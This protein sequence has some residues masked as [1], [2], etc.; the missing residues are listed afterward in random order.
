MRRAQVDYGF[1]ATGSPRSIINGEH[2]Q[3]RLCSPVYFDAPRHSLDRRKLRFTV[4]ARHAERI[5]NIR[6]GKTL[7]G[8]WV[9]ALP[10]CLY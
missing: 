7:L 1:T 4:V 8:C 2:L 3:K 5:K 6:P 10:G 9:V